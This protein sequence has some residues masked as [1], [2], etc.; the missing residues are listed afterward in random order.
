VN[1]AS[2][3][4][5]ANKVYGT[6]IIIGEATRKEAGAR[7][8]ARELDRIAVYGRVEG[9]AIFELLGLAGQNPV[10]QWAP[11][12]ET[13]LERYRARDFAGAVERFEAVIAV[14]GKDEASSVMI[15]R[16]RDFLRTPPPPDWTG[17][18]ALAMK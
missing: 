1:I 17:T 18:T 10:P 2:R 12:Y 16:C 6:A 7:I 15:E 5:G 3:L 11:V 13:G 14:K 8:V 9:I 4:E